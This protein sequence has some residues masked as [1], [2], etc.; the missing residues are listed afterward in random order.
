MMSHDFKSNFSSFTPK[1]SSQNRLYK[2]YFLWNL[3]ETTWQTFLANKRSKSRHLPQN[4]LIQPLW[5]INHF[6]LGFFLMLITNFG[7]ISSYN[8]G[9]SQCQPQTGSPFKTL[10][11]NQRKQSL[12]LSLSLSIPQP[13]SKYLPACHVKTPAGERKVRWWDELLIDLL[14][15]YIDNFKR[16]KAVWKWF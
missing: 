16:V 10:N 7:Y 11:Q 6:C 9:G 2:N 5:S 1:I 8:V 3:G 4:N 14:I 12:S 13:G 15:F